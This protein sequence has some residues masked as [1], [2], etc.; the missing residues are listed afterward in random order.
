MAGF[1][2]FG[3][4]QDSQQ[5]AQQM[6]AAQQQAAL[7]QQAAMAEQQQ[8]QQAMAQQQA[9]ARQQD[10]AG[11]ALGGLLAP[12][13]AP[14]GQMPAPPQMQAPAPGQA[15]M[16]KP[17]PYKAMPSGPAPQGAPAQGGQISAPP[18][19]PAAAPDA[20]PEMQHS[21]M[22]IE[23]AVKLLQDQGLKG[24]DLMEGLNTLRPMLDANAKQQFE[25]A[26]QHHSEKMSEQ[27]QGLQ[28]DRLKEEIDLHKRQA[29]DNTLDR[30]QRKTSNDRAYNLQL[31]QFAMEKKAQDEKLD[32]APMSKE[33]TGSLVDRMLAGDMTTTRGL[34]KADQRAVNEEY[35]AR[36]GSATDLISA[37]QG[38]VA[39]GK[40]ASAAGAQAGN[41]AVVAK[42]LDNMLPDLL[43]Y[44]AA[45][46][47]SNY[48]LL[49]KPL[50]EIRMATNDPATLQLATAMQGAKNTYARLIGGGRTSVNAQQQA[51]HLFSMATNDEGVKYVMDTVGREAK[52]MAAAP[53]EVISS[54][55]GKKEAPAGDTLAAGTV[56][57][58]YKFK[59]GD[60]YDK[61]NWVKQ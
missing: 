2:G 4:Y 52:R 46:P 36:H 25:A 29:S 6:Q 37:R 56:Q 59:G 41:V 27:N 20:A 11:N 55:A 39:T 51:D 21:S 42:E 53:N 14:G 9:K 50:N 44:S 3:A 1:G 33:A 5:Q 40:A 58:G 24:A 54:M 38:V 18:S 10:A 48:T 47:R 30:E 60:R 17:E 16:P 49:N 13:P 22:T 15:S 12:P 23:N 32:A 26:K 8:Q 35:A 57:Q 61:A 7:R 28:Q 45:V 19:A 31:Q 43:K 34:S